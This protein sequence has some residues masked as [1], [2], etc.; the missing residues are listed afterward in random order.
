M[1]PNDQNHKQLPKVGIEILI[2]KLRV[3]EIN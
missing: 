3:G 1:R 2:P